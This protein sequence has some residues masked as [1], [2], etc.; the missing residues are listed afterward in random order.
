VIDFRKRV[1]WYAK[2]MH[3]CRMLKEETRFL[4]SAAQFEDI[5]ARFL[6]WRLRHDEEVRAGRVV[7]VEDEGEL[8]E[9]A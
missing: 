7:A 6:D 3:P 4:E 9:V 1:S 8:A 5:V 2:K